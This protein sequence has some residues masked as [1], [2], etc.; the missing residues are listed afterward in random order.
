MLTIIGCGNTIRGDDGVGVVV[1]Q[2]LA[3]RLARRPVPGVR[4]FDCG[5]AGIQVMFAA[6]GS[7]ALV[8]VDASRTGAAPGTVYRVPGDELARALDPPCS[9]HDFRWDHALSA[10]RKI[11]G[12]AFPRDVIVWLVEAQ[13]VEY[14]LELSAPVAAA[15]DRVVE[16]V[17][18]QITAYAAAHRA[19]DGA[20]LAPA[21]ARRGAVQAAPE[22]AAARLPDQEPAR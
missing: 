14:G 11:Y 6:R 20:A 5:T 16:R 1:A 19:S 7:D 2:R 9:P 15:A 17:L 13:T 8:L 12:D 3:A 22:A 10:G 21:G 18:E 4:V